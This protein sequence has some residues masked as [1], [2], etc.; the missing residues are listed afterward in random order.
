MY[1]YY[2]LRI[3]AICSLI[4]LPQGQF[5]KQP[6]QLLVKLLLS[7]PSSQW[8]LGFQVVQS[9]GFF[10]WFLLRNIVQPMLSGGNSPQVAYYLLFVLLLLC[11]STLLI[12]K[13]RAKVLPLFLKWTTKGSA[14]PVLVAFVASLLSF[15]L[16]E[17][18]NYPRFQF[19]LEMALPAIW[20]IGLWAL[21]LASYSLAVGW[22]SQQDVPD[23][24]EPFYLSR[25]GWLVLGCVLAAT[26]AVFIALRGHFFPADQ[27]LHLDP[28]TGLT[29]I[30]VALSL[31]VAAVGY[32][33]YS[34]GK[35]RRLLH[36]EG[37]TYFALWIIT[38]V[39][40]WLL[41]TPCGTDRPGPFPPNYICYPQVTDSVY[42]I[43]SHYISLG[44]GIL[45]HWF[46]DKPFYMIFLSVGQALFGWQ[47]DRYL[48]F[49]VLIIALMAPLGYAIG[50]RLLNPLAGLFF[51]LLLAGQ[52]AGAV[53]AYPEA[54]GVNVWMENSELLTALLLMI[55][56]L[57]VIVGLG[58]NGQLWHFL[59]AGG[60]IALAGF[61]RLNPWFVLPG[62][63]A[64]VVIVTRRNKGLLIRSLAAFGLGLLLISTPGVAFNRS[65][66]GEYYILQKM[67]DILFFRYDISSIPFGNVVKPRSQLITKQVAHYRLVEGSTIPNDAQVYWQGAVSILPSVADNIAKTILRF[68]LQ[69]NPIPLEMAANN[70]SWAETSQTESWR[71]DLLP[72]QILLATFNLGL[73]FFGAAITIKKLGPKGWIFPI[74][75]F[76]YHFGNGIALTSGGRYLEPVFWIPI[77][78]YSVGIVSMLGLVSGKG[79]GRQTADDAEV[80]TKRSTSNPK[81]F[82][83][84]LMGL[85]VLGSLFMIPNLLNTKFSPSQPAATLKEVLAKAGLPAGV[86]IQYQQLVVVEGFMIHP[87][88]YLS[89]AFHS[90]TVA[91]E[92]T[93]LGSD[94][95]Y[96]ANYYGKSVI[97]PM[98]DGSRVRLI[99]CK[100]RERVFWGVPTILV[101]AL[102]IDQLDNQQVLLKVTPKNFS[103]KASAP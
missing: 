71:Y 8:V 49:Q 89:E 23:S 69:M 96:V 83:F 47:I 58:K 2:N 21:E 36:F 61:T 75:F 95:V 97:G 82:I 20:A 11:V 46:T 94:N 26:I 57:F 22:T 53:I 102:V 31:L 5:L 85:C 80:E 68:P 65:E 32:H 44:Q 16:V 3:E 91:L 50:K 34:L 90:Q 87:R 40:W 78:Y 19:L 10:A 103:C 25:L 92:M 17:P 84:T 64:L 62:T 52:M 15:I 74:V 73:L 56:S 59:L 7:P 28:G 12:Y 66:S 86:D 14:K 48:A 37:I 27:P 1:T 76:S 51:A 67:R 35:G 55:T 77:S 42:S 29:F 30:Q 100:I 54:G 9:T 18:Q 43:G 99:G 79:S 4:Q 93:I 88:F 33:L 6:K 70:Q 39:G 38:V 81:Y 45:N 41:P 98:T 24:P 72:S 101:K 63:I 13:F 60:V